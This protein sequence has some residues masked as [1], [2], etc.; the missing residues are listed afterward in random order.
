MTNAMGDWY[1]FI[2]RCDCGSDRPFTH[3][4]KD[5]EGKPT[6]KVCPLCEERKK[7]SNKKHT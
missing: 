4:V 2:R 7:E 5:D 6:F 3:W 1:R